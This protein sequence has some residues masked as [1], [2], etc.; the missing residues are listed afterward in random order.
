M[1]G[2]AA[3]ERLRLWTVGNGA[4]RSWTSRRSLDRDGLRIRFRHENASPPLASMAGEWVFVPLPGNAT[5]VVLLH[6]FQAIGDHPGNT[7]LIKQAVDRN[8]TAELAA[9]KRAAELGDR[10]STLV[11]SFAD[12]VV[13]PSTLRPVYEFL[14]RVQDWPSLLPHVSRLIVDEAVPNMQTIEMDGGGPAGPVRTMNLVRICFPYHTIVYKQTEPPD[15]VSAH[16]GAWQLRP[17]AQGV[18]VT[19]TNT[20]LVRPDRTGG[21]PGQPAAAEPVGDPIRQALRENSLATLLQAKRSAE[22]GTIPDA[23][24]VAQAAGEVGDT[25]L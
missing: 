6:E 13:I 1:S 22:A 16:V 3:E 24:R 17:I 14:Y 21:Q 8:S 2:G 7:V 19:A 15:V 25:E 4:V 5:S 18:R 11:H 10:L 9:V 20:V 12:S 23:A